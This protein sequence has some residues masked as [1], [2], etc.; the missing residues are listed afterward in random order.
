MKRILVLA[1]GLLAGAALAGG[2]GYLVYDGT[3][4]QALAERR[5]RAATAAD[6]PNAAPPPSEAASAHSTPV[7]PPAAAP[8]ST[9][10]TALPTAE[11]RSD[12]APSAKSQE[13]L[14]EQD[15][16][17]R[18]GLSDENA[19]VAQLAKL[20]GVSAPGDD[21]C[22]AVKQSAVRCHWSSGGF[23]EIRALDRPVAIK[24][25]DQKKRV[26]HLLLTRLNDTEATLRAGE[27]SQNISLAVLGRYFHGEFVTLWRTPPG[28]TGAVKLGDAG[29]HVDWLAAH[30]SKLNGVEPPAAG[31]R[32]GPRM[33]KQVDLFQQAHGLYVDGIL[34]PLTAMHINRAV[35]VDEPRLR[36]R[37]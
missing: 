14:S 19:A 22:E 24:L 33:V 34:G 36:D 7:T 16:S 32:Y 13:L 6:R 8:A 30:L 11:A 17:S 25:Q 28:F 26:A 37:R 9:P 31:E 4:A 12:D 21:P 29:P 35:G 10:N 1:L 2:I 20:W 23:G 3:M 18:A 15:G 5:A 27:L